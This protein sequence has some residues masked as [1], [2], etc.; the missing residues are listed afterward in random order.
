[1]PASSALSETQM[2]GFM[3]EA[4]ALAARA[5]GSTSPNPM[6]GCVIVAGGEVVGRGWHRAAGQPHAEVE[7]LR[8]AAER[9]R[10]ATA[11]VTLEPCN[12]HGRT[13]PCTEALIDAGIS[14]VVIASKDTNP[15]AGGGSQRLSAAGIR[16]VD[17]VC[18]HESLELNRSFFHF[19]STTR[20]YTI[21]KFA[22]SLD[23]KIATRSRHS[24]WITGEQTRARAHQLRQA[25][26]A[27]VVGAQTAIDD[28]P[29]LTTR[30][31]SNEQGDTC[32]PLR[33][34]LDGHGRVPLENRLF[35]PAL[36]GRTLVISTTAM[37]D[38]KAQ[39]LGA[40]GVEVHSIDQQGGFIDTGHL[41]DLLGQ[42][43]VQSMLVEGGRALLGS[44]FDQRNINEVHTSLAPILIGGREA[45][46]PIGGL[47]IDKLSE[48]PRLLNPRT[49]QIGQDLLISGRLGYPANPADPHTSHSGA[50]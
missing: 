36:P 20:P 31:V 35:D 41:L 14:E 48:A 18:E 17:G 7:A 3:Q 8:D 32:H 29:R 1:M 47:G 40:R 39:A 26:D 9:A 28:N 23:G 11:F 44:F 42:R 25:V 50:M 24:Q 43:G 19:Q 10:G 13:P 6:V 46:S 27:I 21:A 30:N 5:L 2:T 45:L 34:V 12:H 16:V 4:L 22:C 33:I 38:E 37:P 49:E 15:L